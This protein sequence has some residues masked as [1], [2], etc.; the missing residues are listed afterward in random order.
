MAIIK[1]FRGF[2]YDLKKAGSFA[3]LISPPYD[4]LSEA[5]RQKFYAK[6]PYNIVRLILGRGIGDWYKHSAGL[7]T[8][9]QKSGLIAQDQEECLYIYRQDFTVAG[10]RYDRTGF[11]AL[12][13]LEEPGKS[14][15]PHEKTFPGPV[16]DRFKLLKTARADFGQILL[17]Y[18]DKNMVIDKLLQM[19]TRKKPKAAGEDDYGIKHT[20]WLLH[21][22]NAVARIKAYVSCLPWVS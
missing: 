19:Q 13:E 15:L 8:K 21:D 1:P 16:D 7:W 6:S 12:L 4:V 9:W 3:S 20:L 10:R 11:I 14:I 5:D 22:K 17:I 2:R 18:D